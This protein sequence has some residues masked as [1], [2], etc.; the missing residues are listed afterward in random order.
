ML[1]LEKTVVVADGS[2]SH[3]E[4]GEPSVLPLSY[5]VILVVVVSWCCL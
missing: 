2:M 1:E 4:T 5:Q 3:G